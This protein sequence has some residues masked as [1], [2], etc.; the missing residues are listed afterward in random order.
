K[1]TDLGHAPASFVGEAAGDNSGF[2]IASAGDVNGD[3]YADIL[4][5]AKN[6]KYAGKN[7]VGKVYLLLGSAAG[8][9]NSI[10]PNNFNL[11]KAAACFIGEN[12]DD[13]AGYSVASAGDVNGDGL[14]DILIGAYGNDQGGTDSGQVYLILGQVNINWGMFF[15]LANASASF[16]GEAADDQA[17]YSVASAG[18]VNNDSYGDFMIGAPGN[19]GNQ[20]KT[21]LIKGRADVDWDTRYSLSKAENSFRGAPGSKSGSAVTSA[22]DVNKDGYSDFLIGAPY[23]TNL[24]GANSGQVYLIRG[25]QIANW[26]KDFNLSNADGSFI[27][28]AIGDEAGT[29]VA[30]AGDVNGDKRVLV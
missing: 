2:C 17:G 14:D 29:C 9:T 25:K 3:G 7:A 10:N 22:G 4:I 18:D 19:A 28:E 5:G 24:Q 27:G 20:G 26:G 30:S 1:N 23:D 16:V 21:Y 12:A 6:A 13:R 8:W 15:N 11:A